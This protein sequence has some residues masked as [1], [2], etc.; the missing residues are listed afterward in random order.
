MVVRPDDRR[1]ADEHQ[2]AR[3][4]DDG[5]DLGVIKVRLHKREFG[6]E[7][8]YESRANKAGDVLRVLHVALR[9]VPDSLT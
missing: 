9:S 3:E 1:P 7:H 6:D 8:R 4:M 5:W 2:N